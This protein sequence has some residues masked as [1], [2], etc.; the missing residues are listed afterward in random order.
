VVAE[1]R[2]IILH[3]KRHPELVDDEH[4]FSGTL[5][6]QDPEGK[7]LK[8]DSFVGLQFRQM[9][10]RVSRVLREH[11]SAAVVIR[12]T[13][14]KGL[15]PIQLG[16]ETRVLLRDDPVQ[17]IRLMDVQPGQPVRSSEPASFGGGMLRAAYDSL[18][19]AFGERVYLRMRNGNVEDP[20]TG[21][22]RQLAYGP[23]IGW[24]VRGEN[25]KSGSWLPIRLEGADLPDISDDATPEELKGMM[26]G[27]AGALA[28]CRWA[29]V[30]VDDL[31]ERSTKRFFLP[32]T[33]NA[34]RTWIGRDALRERYEKYKKEKMTS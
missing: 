28:S 31:L 3:N 7:S 17:A 29:S 25:N 8:R 10:V 21:R 19:A 20:I 26:E 33:W 24:R 11:T 18:A 6:L 34:G 12:R 2:T 5:E 16:E 4:L 15:R 32:R 22:W 27:L 30:S 9:M 14:R 23:K 1:V 13:D